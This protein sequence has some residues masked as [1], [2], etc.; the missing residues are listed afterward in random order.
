MKLRAIDQVHISSVKA[1]S[2]RP[3]EEFEV[4]D[5]VGKDLMKAHPDKFSAV[6]E[7][8]QAEAAAATD[9]KS[10]PAPSNKA[11]DAPANKAANRRKSKG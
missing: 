1:D 10:E 4:S 6:E 9:A 11:E 7:G 3:G 2:L 5:A 8:E